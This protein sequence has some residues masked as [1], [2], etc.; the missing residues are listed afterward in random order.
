M[1]DSL[2]I[3]SSTV[4]RW[5][6]AGLAVLLLLWIT[7]FDSHSL[8]RR[9]SWHAEHE[10][11][12]Q[13]NARLE[14]QIDELQKQLARPLSDETVERIAREEYGMSRPGETVYR[15]ESR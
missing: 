5:L 7:F 2:P 4:G 13:E 1:V 10:R 3:S 12:Q 8:L 11:L 14:A 9:Y 15:V 6:L